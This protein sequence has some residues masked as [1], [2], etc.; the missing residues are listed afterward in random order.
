MAFIKT[1]PSPVRPDDLLNTL[2]LR[3]GFNDQEE[4]KTPG[5][6]AKP[7]QPAS[8]SEVSPQGS[9]MIC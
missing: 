7:A 2:R 3:Y 8:D 1:K 6:L 5:I 4:Q 9:S